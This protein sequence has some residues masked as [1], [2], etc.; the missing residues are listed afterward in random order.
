MKKGPYGTRLA[1]GA[2][3]IIP[4]LG[5]IVPKM[6]MKKEPVGLAGALFS[7]VQLR[8]LAL[9]IG[10][11]DRRFQASE[12][13]RLVGSGSGAV[14]RQLERLSRAGI[15][16]VTSVGRTKVY[17]ANR[18]CPIFKELHGIAVKTVG[19]VEPLRRALDS[20]ESKIDVAFVYGS[21]ARGEDTAQSDIDVMAIGEG[22]TYSEV[23]AALQKA[24]ETLGR[25]INPN[26][27]TAAEWKRKLAG[28]SAFIGRVIQQPKLFV[29]GSEHDLQRLG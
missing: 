14:Q 2:R 25:R 24:E 16:N 12:I 7:P 22:L 1:L 19:L 9:V 8:L 13:I 21:I 26:L 18:H 20:L 5:I 10:Q 6:G 15:L 23:Y 4:E 29:L 17:Q 3:L 28:N 11:P 27:M